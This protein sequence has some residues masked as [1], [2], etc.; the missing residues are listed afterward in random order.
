M[1]DRKTLART[2]VTVKVCNYVTSQNI[3]Y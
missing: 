3:Y 2:H 1:Q